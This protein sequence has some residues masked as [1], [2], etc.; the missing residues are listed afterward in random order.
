MQQTFWK[1]ILCIAICLSVGFLGSFYEVGQWYSQ[2]AK[3]NWTLP[4]WVFAPVWTVLYVLMGVS[5]W[6][7]WCKPQHPP[8]SSTPYQLFFL[9]LFVNLCWPFFFFYQKQLGISVVI[10]AILLVLV[11]WTIK[12]FRKYSSIS[13]VLLL[14]YLGWVTYATVL[15]IMIWWMN[16]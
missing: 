12:S 10:I 9:Q 15:N 7:I 13:S 14:P 4:N 1:L 5:L 3:P 16:G 6:F 11:A 2:L 8:L